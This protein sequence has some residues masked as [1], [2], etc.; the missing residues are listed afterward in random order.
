M[1]VVVSTPSRIHFG[2]LR[3]HEHAERSFGGMGMMIDSPRVELELGASRRW[4]VSGPAAARARAFAERALASSNAAELPPALAVHVKSMAP[5]HRGLGAGTQLALAIAAGVRQLIGLAPGTAEQ[6][7]QAVGRGGRSAVGSHGFVHGGLIWETGR[8]P[9][10]PLAGLAARVALPSA[11]RIVLVAPRGRR[12]LS[13]RAET[14]AFAR[15]P[16]VPPSRTRRLEFLAEEHILPAA[17]CG[18]VDAFGAGVY[19]YGRLSGECFAGVQGGPYASAEIA[20]CVAA[21][22][23]FGVQGV[24]QSSWGPT[25]FAITGD[26]GSADELVAGLRA[27]SHWSEHET[28]VATADNRGAI[29]GRRE[30]RDSR[31]GRVARRGGRRR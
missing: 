13:G 4:L 27:Q 6:L 5:P 14:S 15:L 18:A 29:V 24:G 26:A 8:R 10:E 3:V 9:G 12:G 28:T 2:L 30:T 25:V 21:I 22:R 19:E 16:K 17:Q 31:L 20:E 7:A 23:H 1:H 11:W